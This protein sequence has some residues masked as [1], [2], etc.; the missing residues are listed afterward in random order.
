LLK[1][2]HP[3]LKI[4]VSIGGWGGCAAC[5]E[6]FASA[7]RRNTFAKTVVEFLK[8]NEVDGLDLDWEYPVIEGFPG[9]RFD[10][11]DAHNFTAL[12]K[13]LRSE[14]G[15]HYLLSFA[16]GGFINYLERSIEWKAV[17]PQV[18]FVNLMTYDL[19]GG[20]SGV[21]GHHT[22]L[23]GVLSGQESTTKCVQW[24]LD[25]KTAP[26]K[27]IIGAAFYA[28]VWENVPDTNHGLYQRGNFLRGVS[29]KDFPA[30]FSDSSGFAYYWDEKSMA[31]YR[32]NASKR[33]FAT[34][35]DGRSIGEKT[36]FVRRKK[37]GGI[38]FWQLMDDAPAGGLLTEIYNDLKK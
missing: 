15:N 1:K 10:S 2:D 18:D 36:K 32:Y 11:A 3:A 38:M 23:N 8:Q 31:P 33:L 16:A 37:L 9:H 29:Y 17:L 28:R 4:M 14:M 21:T 6:M 34:F 35:D 19:V 26:G 30:Y 5:S 12:V 20:Y 24:L 25:K 27:L 13:A 7:T 22:P